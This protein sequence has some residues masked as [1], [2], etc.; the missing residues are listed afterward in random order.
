MRFLQ[1]LKRVRA[2]ED[3]TQTALYAKQ[4]LDGGGDAAE[5]TVVRQISQPRIY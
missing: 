4:V 5:P 3:H 2:P 1:D